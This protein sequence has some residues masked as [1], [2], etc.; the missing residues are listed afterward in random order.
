MKHFLKIFI[1]IELLL[2]SY[3]FTTSVYN[4]YEKNHVT[5]NNMKCYAIQENDPELMGNFFEEL[6]EAVG[7]H[8][9]MMTVNTITQTDKTEYDLYCMPFERFSKKQPVTSS[10]HYNYKELTKD[11]FTDSTGL[12]YT[13]MPDEQIKELAS[14]S[15]L[16]LKTVLKDTISYGVF[17]K[18]YAVDFL[19]LFAVIQIVYCIYTSYSLKKIGIKKSMGFS[20]KKIQKEQIANAAFWL[21]VISAAITVVLSFYLLLNNR[22]SLTFLAFIVAYFAAVIL[23]NIFC[24]SNT[25]VLVSMV[26]LEAMV[27]NKSM[28]RSMNIAA[29]SVKVLFTI[30]I[31][32]TVIL[33]LDQAKNFKETNQKILDYQMLDN[34]YTANGFIS[35]EYDRAINNPEILEKY[36]ENVKNIYTENDAMLCNTSSLELKNIPGIETQVPEYELNKVVINQNY[37]NKFTNITKDGEAISL[38][39]SYTALVSEKYRNIENEIREFLDMEL[40]MMYTYDKMYGFETANQGIPEYEL[41]Y[42]DD[43]SSIRCCTENGFENLG[44]N[45]V[46]VDNGN[47]GKTYYLDSINSRYIFFELNSREEFAS[48]LV[49]NDLDNFISAGTLLTPFYDQMENVQFVL[50]TLIVFAGVFVISLLFIIYISGYIDIVVNKSRYAL[51]EI[52]GFSHKKILSRRYVMLAAEFILIAALSIIN[53]SIICAAAAVCLDIVLHEILYRIFIKNKIY[54]IVKGA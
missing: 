17:F 47:S 52:I 6:S 42:I 28:N 13:D 5:S 50:K 9:V 26:S 10:L 29:Q 2:F 33:V 44:A 27:K 11:D 23:L 54:E 48:M 16:T 51:K 4:I 3:I 37:L 30:L 31:S 15:D 21:A 49:K 43:T 36:A 1:L 8:K 46:L 32:I 18:L 34:Y 41:I 45:L 20:N 19:V 38:G 40:E 35:T 7:N 24:I 53:H 25:S 12:F 14:A 39:N 22:F